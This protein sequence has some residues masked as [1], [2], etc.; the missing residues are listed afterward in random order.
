MGYQDEKVVMQMT[1]REDKSLEHVAP[2]GSTRTYYPREQICLDVQV[3][4]IGQY[5]LEPDTGTTKPTLKT[6]VSG[7][8]LLEDHDI[9]MIGLPESKTR[10]LKLNFYVRDLSYSKQELDNGPLFEPTKPL[11]RASLTFCGW[12]P[13]VEIRKGHN[14]TLNCFVEESLLIALS[15][16][17]TNGRLR[18]MKLELSLKDLYTNDHPMAPVFGN[19]NR[20]LRPN[21]IDSTTGLSKPADGYITGLSM[22]LDK[23]DMRPTE[24]EEGDTTQELLEVRRVPLDP[25]AVAIGSLTANV[26]ALHNTLKWVVGIGAIY[27]LLLTFK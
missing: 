22:L 25:V 17:I 7:E 13:D 6:S 8:V 5:L 15:D 19:S 14:W 16:R 2:N 4:Q 12:L 24:I 21:R 1:E 27:L 23:A 10:S 3:L 26:A 18:G 11:G 20:F 9:S